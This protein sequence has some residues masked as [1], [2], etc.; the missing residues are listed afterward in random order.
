M[1]EPRKITVTICV[2][3][4]CDTDQ[5]RSLLV[6]EGLEVDRLLPEIGI[7]TGQVDGEEVVEA[8]RAVKG[9]SSIERERTVGVPPPDSPLQ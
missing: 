2:E 4:G 1:T 5:V 7:I 3:D 8:L 9:V 6:A